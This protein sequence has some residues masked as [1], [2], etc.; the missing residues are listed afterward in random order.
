MIKRIITA[1]TEEKSDACITVSPSDSGRVIVLEKLPHPRFH[2]AVLE[3]VNRVLDE[4]NVTDVQVRVLDFGALNFVIE[5]R[6]RAA[7]H[8]AEREVI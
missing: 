4:E 8:E 7:I 2:D 1:G 6:L 3:M 5:A